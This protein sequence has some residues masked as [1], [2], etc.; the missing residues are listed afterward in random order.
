MLAGADGFGEG[1]EK[2]LHSRSVRV[3]QDQREGIICTGLD[4]GVDVGGDVALVAEARRSFT[5]FPPDM[6]DAALLADPRFILEIQAQTLV[7]MR[8][9]NFF[10]RSSGS[11]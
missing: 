4:G 8:V 9:L 3:R 2:R 6:T 1:V 10:Q 11:F 5:A 7:F